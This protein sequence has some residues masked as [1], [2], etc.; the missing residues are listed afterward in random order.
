MRAIRLKTEYL[1]NPI[2]IDIVNPRLFWNC[3]GGMIQTAYQIMAVCDGKTV[4]DSGKVKS[5]QMTHIPYGGSLDSRTHVEW[6]V[7]LWDENDM[8][9]DWS[10]QAVFEMGLLHASDWKA[11]WIAG[12]Y[13]A[14]KK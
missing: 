9:G 10:E 1:Y 6:R 5:G 14:D 3:E 8:P 4:W 7:R 13:R 12:N 2:G 11:R